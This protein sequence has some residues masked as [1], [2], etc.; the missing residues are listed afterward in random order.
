MTTNSQTW[1]NREFS[2]SI[3]EIKIEYDE[4]E[5]SLIIENYP[6][7]S[8]INLADIDGKIDKLTLKSLPNL[9]AIRIYNCKLEFLIIE[10]CSEIKILN[11]RNNFLTNLNFIKDLSNLKRLEID[12]NKQINSGIEYLPENL[13]DFTYKSTGLFEVL[14]SYQYDWKL[15]KENLLKLKEKN[16]DFQE[17]LFLEK[18]YEELEEKYKNLKNQSLLL[19]NHIRSGGSFNQDQTKEIMFNLEKE[20][21]GIKSSK[22]ELEIKVKELEKKV[23][24]AEERVISINKISIPLDEDP[25]FWETYEKTLNLLRTKSVFINARY[26]TISFLNLIHSEWEKTIKKAE[27]KTEFMNFTSNSLG[28]IANVVTFGIPKIVG[29]SLKTVNNLW[30]IYVRE[31]KNRDINLIL[32]D[33]RELEEAKNSYESLIFFIN[34]NEGNEKL[35]ILNLDNFLPRSGEINSFETDHKILNILLAEKILKESSISFE[36]FKTIITSLL[37]NINVLEKEWNSQYKAFKSSFNDEKGKKRLRIFLDEQRFNSQIQ[38]KEIEIEDLMKHFRIEIESKSKNPI[39]NVRKNKERKKLVDELLSEKNVS[40]VNELKNCLIK[41]FE[42]GKDDLR[43]SSLEVIV[44][45]KTI[46]ASLRN[47]LEEKIKEE[48]LL[49]QHVT[50]P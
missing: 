9:K 13:T 17:F 4:F 28:G 46:I 27:I 34:N 8:E 23:T 50:H 2:K 30:N 22:E 7:L 31:D 49:T 5:G 45:E 38:A 16:I 18:K 36:K 10:N 15:Y 40:K 43:L 25:L 20:V 12:G 6:D 39:E 32:K 35:N 33:E 14:K 37:S 44:R 3:R 47:K 1:F 48:E 24:E 19:L 26:K 42:K 29:E 41:T 21:K 11:V